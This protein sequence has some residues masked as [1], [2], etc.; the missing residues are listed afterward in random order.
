MIS[1]EN[2]EIPKSVIAESRRVVLE[3][4][5]TKNKRSVSSEA[6]ESNSKIKD[7]KNTY[8]EEKENKNYVLF[9]RQ[10][11]AQKFTLG[12]HSKFNSKSSVLNMTYLNVNSMEKHH[13]S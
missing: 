10:K 5:I 4:E 8:K 13:L 3:R 9:P 2:V 12:N 11:D 7:P 6:E 1:S